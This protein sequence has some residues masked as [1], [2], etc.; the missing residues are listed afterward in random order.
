MWRCFSGFPTQP[1]PQV[2]SAG[3]PRLQQPHGA[4][5]AKRVNSAGL[6][7]IRGRCSDDQRGSAGIFTSLSF[8][9]KFPC[10]RRLPIVKHL[11]DKR[12]GKSQITGDG[13]DS[14][15]RG[16]FL[17]WCPAT[18]RT[19]TRGSERRRS[20]CCGANEIAAREN[21]FRLDPIAQQASPQL[22]HAVPSPSRTP[23]PTSSLLHGRPGSARL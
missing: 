14:W 2:I 1:R 3:N 7:A 9:W 23:G 4:V 11:D 16:K 22:R 20:Q 18:F 5:Y 15:R 21:V 6:P 10:G 8:S 17:D 12:R 19:S 13:L